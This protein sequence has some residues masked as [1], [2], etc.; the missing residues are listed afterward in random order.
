[1]SAIVVYVIYQL[2]SIR[3]ACAHSQMKR[4]RRA[5]LNVEDISRDRTDSQAVV[6]THQH[7][8][9]DK[10]DGV[11]PLCCQ[12]SDLGCV[13]VL[14]PCDLE[15]Q[16]AANGSVHALSAVWFAILQ[17]FTMCAGP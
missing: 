12:M 7:V 13:Q 11:R 2:P 5:L 10:I 17:L 16:G 1:M 4:V 8:I 15:Q 6:I 9:D 3:D 14:A